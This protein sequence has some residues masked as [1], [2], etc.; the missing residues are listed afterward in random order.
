MGRLT[1]AQYLQNDTFECKYII[2]KD[3][4]SI[5][6]DG[7]IWSENRRSQGLPIKNDLLSLYK[8]VI[9]LAK[10]VKCSISYKYK[11][12]QSI[13]DNYEKALIEL[14]NAN[15]VFDKMLIVAKEVEERKLHYGCS[16]DV[17]L[18]ELHDLSHEYDKIF[19][20]SSYMIIQ[21]IK[22]KLED[23]KKDFV[24]NS[25]GVPCKIFL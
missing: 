5:R 3:Y 17:K 24:N 13:I 21:G 16:D 6:S 20:N 10:E 22:H 2:E 18:N 11:T 23:F 8:E 7:S 4:I 15:I 19:Y 9:S 12:K 1:D 25:D 14:E